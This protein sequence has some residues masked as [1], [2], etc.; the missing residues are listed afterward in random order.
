MTAAVVSLRMLSPSVVTVGETRAEEQ[1]YDASPA[2]LR[3]IVQE[4]YSF[5]WRALRRS[6][7]LESSVEDLAQKVLLVVARRLAEIR[8]GAEKAFLYRTAA[9][10]ALAERRAVARRREDFSEKRL[11]FVA[12][13]GGDAADQL[14]ANERRQQLDD[15]LEAMDDDLRSVFVLY[16][17]EELTMAEIADILELAPGTVASRL[18]RARDEFQ[19]LAKKIVGEGGAT[20]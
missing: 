20:S 1:T 3:A 19:T 11:D 5:L 17:L 2:R 7:V 18:R 15:V 12:S 9:N 6:G 8:P 14:A 4:H 10:V 16:E 13:P